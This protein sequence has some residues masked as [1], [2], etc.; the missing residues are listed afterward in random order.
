MR[1]PLNCPNCGAPIAG[2]TC[3]YCGTEFGEEQEYLDA[4]RELIINQ[5][6][7]L[8]EKQTEG[9]L[10]IINSFLKWR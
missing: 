6:M 1:R 10:Q 3:D 2:L 9:L 8:N 4:K 7:L 5:Q